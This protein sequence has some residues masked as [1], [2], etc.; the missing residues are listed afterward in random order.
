MPKE[1]YEVD[2]YSDEYKAFLRLLHGNYSDEQLM[3]SGYVQKKCI[4]FRK[5]SRRYD[6]TW[7]LTKD[8]WNELNLRRGVVDPYVECN[9]ETM[10][11]LRKRRKAEKS[12]SKEFIKD[13]DRC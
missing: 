1:R 3:R 6:C 8:G 10:A 7:T 9:K 5:D 4:L 11:L 2:H 13:N 12:F